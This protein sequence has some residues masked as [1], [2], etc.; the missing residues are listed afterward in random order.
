MT[1]IKNL[2]VI[3][4]PTGVGK[5]E[6][7]L[8][9]ARLFDSP[10][11]S[12]DSRQMYADIPIGSAAPTEEE[13]KLVRHYFIGTLKLDDYYSAARYEQEAIDLICTL[14]ETKDTLVVTGGSMMYLD[15]L[16]YGIDDIPTISPEVRNEVLRLYNE[17]GLDFMLS[18]LQQKDPDYYATVD[19]RNPKRVLHAIEVCMMTGGTYTSLRKNK[20][21]ERPF[22]IIKIGLTLP[23]EELYSR[24]N[25]RVERMMEDGL[26]D[27]A[28]RV[29]PFKKFN[30]LNTVG[31]K[32][33]FN[34]FD[35]ATTP[36]GTVWTKEYAVEKIKQNTRIYSRKQMTW[37]R[38]DNSITWF[39][40][41]EKDKI[42]S[43]ITSRINA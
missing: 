26:V 9:V 36:E 25:S 19:R 35:G 32:E 6:L 5:T 7:S 40:P 30:S 43:F 2:I 1:C 42:T 15:A 27:E 28:Q 31:Y 11:I 41:F 38:R 17:N 37:F 13:R 8:Y 39:S 16:C 22:N 14:F 18:I 29:Y 4:G 24:I 10:I 20:A 12:A 34:W 33:L 21:A 3:L 23:R